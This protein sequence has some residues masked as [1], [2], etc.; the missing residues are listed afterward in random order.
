MLSLLTSFKYFLCWLGGRWWWK[1]NIGLISL[2]LGVELKLDNIPNLQSS[3]LYGN[4]SRC[5]QQYLNLASTLP[6]IPTKILG[7][8]IRNILKNCISWGLENICLYLPCC[9]TPKKIEFQLNCN[10]ACC[11]NEYNWLL[12]GCHY[13]RVLLFIVSGEM[14]MRTA[15]NIV[16]SWWPE[17]KFSLS[18]FCSLGKNKNRPRTCAASRYPDAT[19]K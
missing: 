8:Q 15:V 1:S 5:R 12:S 16:Q 17:A 19:I 3:P 14:Y 10:P 4:M 9:L 11:M 6:K 7:F 18:R 2:E 13:W